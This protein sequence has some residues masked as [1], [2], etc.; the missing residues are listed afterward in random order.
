[1]SDTETS[2]IT[3]ALPDS[4]R[5]AYIG[6]TGEHCSISNVT[7]SRD[8]E[9]VPDGYIKRIAEKI[10]YINVPDG[11]V[12]NIQSD[13]FRTDSTDGIILNDGHTLNISFHSMSLP[14]ARLVWHC[15]YF[16]IFSSGNSRINGPEFRE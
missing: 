4:S 13:G 5:W 2:E 10:S 16:S 15:P 12:P 6:L 11:D 9:E 8:D 14:T 3:I 1:M 7:I